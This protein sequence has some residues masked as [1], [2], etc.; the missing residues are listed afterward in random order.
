[1]ALEIFRSKGDDKQHDNQK[2]FYADKNKELSIKP[3]IMDIPET[4]NDRCLKEKNRKVSKELSNKLSK[5]LN[6]ELSKEISILTLASERAATSNEKE[7]SRIVVCK[8][9]YRG[10][11]DNFESIQRSFFD[12]N[13]PSL[14]PPGSSGDAKNI[15]PLLEPLRSIGNVTA[16]I[17]ASEG[18]VALFYLEK[19][20]RV[21]SNRLRHLVL[22][23]DG[24]KYA[25]INFSIEN[26][27]SL[28]APK[29]E[30]IDSAL[31]EKDSFSKGAIVISTI[32]KSVETF[33]SGER[34]IRR[35]FLVLDLIFV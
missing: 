32:I 2:I 29:D 35:L 14:E 3:S 13:T 4:T 23:S 9:D 33:F 12:L 31:Y 15:A 34:C 28:L 19:D 22:I 30:S 27:L 24:G 16:R 26:I 20:C 25:S 18:A 7:I 6:D 11:S 5:D 8:G 10:N 21:G 17:P 1:M